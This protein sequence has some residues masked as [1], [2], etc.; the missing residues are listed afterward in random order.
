MGKFETVEET[1]NPVVG[2]HNSATTARPTASYTVFLDISLN[3]TVASYEGNRRPGVL[4]NDTIVVLAKGFDGRALSTC[5]AEPAAALS[6]VHS[7]SSYLV[8]DNELESNT[9]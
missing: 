3:T 5:K 1:L 6:Y 4:N 8:P 9:R 7:S 2:P